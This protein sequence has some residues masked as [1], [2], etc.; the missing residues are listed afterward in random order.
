[1]AAPASRAKPSA[2][3]PV[4]IGK[5]GSTAGTVSALAAETLGSEQWGLTAVGAEAAWP[6]TRGAGVV[7]A[8]VDTGAD[9]SH[10]DL[11]G[12]LLPEI[13]LVGDGA[14]GDPMGHGTHVSG[15]I[16]AAL[17]GKGIAG[18]ANEV[19]VLPVRA[20]DADG[21]GDVY[22]VTDG[23][24]RAV[25]AGASV[26]NLSLGAQSANSVLRLAVADAHNRGV[27]VV[28]AVGNSYTQGN[29]TEYP[30][31]FANVI[32][33]SSVATSG[34][35]SS[36]ANSGGH[37]DISAPGEDIL[38]TVPGGLWEPW[39]GTS[40]ATPFVSAAAALVR[41]A[42]PSFG[43]AQVAATLTSTAADD[44]SGNGR[45][46]Y[47]GSGIL[48]ADRAV[49]KAARAPYGVAAPAATAKVTAISGRSKLRVDIN[50]DRVTKYWSFQVQ[51][52]TAQGEWVSTP[53]TYKTQGAAQTLVVN[54]PAGT[55]RVVVPPKVGYRGTTSAA[56]R[57]VR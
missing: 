32:G 54:L 9:P 6:I 14:T 11:A 47:F 48:R 20:L 28:A 21:S 27:S 5:T 12:R 7:V 18:L 53:K 22:T 34:R 44:S 56:V 57:L 38:S 50:P 1:M 31:G 4:R 46:S 33:V 17:D 36:F 41:A 42:N 40:M 52:R 49:A 2:A 55:Y 51:A 8:V 13:D 24:N 35:S 23:I 16:A 45:D 30:A 29:A 37:V 25:A 15:I 19:Q 26:V 10:P 39:N 43:P 3:V